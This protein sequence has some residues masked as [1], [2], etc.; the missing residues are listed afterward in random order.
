MPINELLHAR[1]LTVFTINAPR[2]SEE[3]TF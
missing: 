1:V 2:I 3:V